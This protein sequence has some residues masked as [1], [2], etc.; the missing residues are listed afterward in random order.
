MTIE[1]SDR[2]Y[3]KHLNWDDGKLYCDLLVID[4]KNDWRMIMDNVEYKNV[5]A[6]IQG[7]CTLHKGKVSSLWFNNDG[8]CTDYVKNRNFMVVPVRDIC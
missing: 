2:K 1:I 6:Y 3:W 5:R 8:D 4:G 7:S